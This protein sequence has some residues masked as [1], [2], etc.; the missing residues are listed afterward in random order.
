MFKNKA[1]L[2]ARPDW[3]ESSNRQEGNNPGMSSA[4][5]ASRFF[6][7]MPESAILEG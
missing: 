1:A 6:N 2:E 3:M 4:K 5:K 7:R